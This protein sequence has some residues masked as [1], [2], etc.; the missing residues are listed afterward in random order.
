VGARPLLLVDP[1]VVSVRA[2]AQRV[3]LPN[4]GIRTIDG[5]DWSLFELAGTGMGVDG[6]ERFELEAEQDR[7]RFP[8]KI[9]LAGGLRLDS[10]G[11]EDDDVPADRP[12]GEAEQVYGLLGRHVDLIYGAVREAD[13]HGQ[14]VAR[15]D[16]TSFLLDWRNSDKIESAKLALIVEIAEKVSTTVG[17]I[18]HRPRR[19]LRRVRTMERA[20]SV[21]QIDPAGIRWLVRQP[22]R[23]LAERAGPRQRVLA[24]TREETVDTHENRVVCDFLERSASECRLWLRDNEDFKSGERWKTVDRYSS[25]VRR[26]RRTSELAGVRPARGSVHP[27]YVLQHEARYSRVWDWYQKLRRRQEQEDQMWRW[28]HRT[29]AESLR[30]GLAWAIDELEAEWTEGAGKSRYDRPLLLHG[31][32]HYG[33]FVHERTPFTGWIFEFGSRLRSLTILTGGRIAA[34]ESSFKTGTRLHEL[35]PDAVVVAHDPYRIDGPHRFL[36][37]WSR[38]RFGSTDDTASSVEELGRAV[39]QSRGSAL[40][41]A[42]LVEPTR[43]PFGSAEPEVRLIPTMQGPAVPVHRYE[44]SMRPVR[45]RRKFVSLIRDVLLSGMGS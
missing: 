26:W 7:Q 16:L 35:A 5:R 2:R 4:L 40:V 18:A 27:N 22:G 9:E 44:V 45:S 24:V 29:F 20:A 39:G 25:S 19:E 14:G 6:G 32:Q 23:T 37:L 11:T 1:G 31:E 30:L 28:S 13:S 36:A 10:G 21:R 43:D 38:L 41:N 3:R 33:Q 15:L 34:F 17:Q 8:I 42:A 12:V